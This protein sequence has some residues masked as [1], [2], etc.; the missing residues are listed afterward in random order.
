MQ[1]VTR[2]L[3][4]IITELP[5]ENKLKRLVQDSGATGYTIS[6]ATGKGSQGKREGSW[7]Q[8]SNIR[9]EVICNEEVA[10]RI[11]KEI[12]AKYYNDFAM[13]AFTQDITVMRPDKF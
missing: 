13:V 1:Y 10:D 7:D 8:N 4:T 5:L 12:F 11:N 3:V 6:Q 9:V 2:K